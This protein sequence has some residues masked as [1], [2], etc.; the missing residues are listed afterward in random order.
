M[1]SHV[2]GKSW[3][4]LSLAAS[5]RVGSVI[6]AGKVL[7]V[8]VRVDLGGGDVGVAEQLLH[9]AQ[10]AARLQQVRS[11]GVPEQVRMHAQVQ[12]LAARPVRDARLH[13]P[14]AEPRAVAA[15]EQRGLAGACQRG[16]LLQPDAQ[17]L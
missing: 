13:G 7:E 1:L 9:P 15:H 10:L 5:P 2:S 12:S 4:N 16:T 6:N 3:K 11:K 8:K 17:R 14:W